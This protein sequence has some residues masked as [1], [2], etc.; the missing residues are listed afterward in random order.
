MERAE[1]FELDR[2]V[3][4]TAIRTERFKTGCVSLGLLVPLTRRTVS[5]NATL[6]YVLRRG[7]ARLPDMES[8]AAELDG[9]YGARIEPTLRKKGEIQIIGFYADFPDEAFLPERPDILGR[10]TSLMGEMLL[11]PATRGGRLRADFVATERQN[12]LDDINA[13]I[14]DKR[15]YAE[16]RVRELMF[17][18]ESYGLSKLGTSA[19]A[20]K[21]SQITLT[22]HYREVISTAPVEIFYCGPEDPGRV[23]R[24]MR[25]ALA[26]LPRAGEI[27]YPATH[28]SFERRSGAPRR[29]TERMDVTQGR[30][31]VGYRLG[32][33][34]REPNYARFLV[35]NALFGDSATSKLYL[36]LRERLSLCYYV[37]SWIDRHKGA[38]FV[39]CGIDFDKAGE[40]EAE[41]SAGLQAIAR[42]EIEDW[43]LEGA[44]REVIGALYSAADEVA[45][46]E[47]QS[48]ESAILGLGVGPEELAALASEVTAEELRDMAAGLR[49]DFVYFLTGE[50]NN[51]A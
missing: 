26:G 31:I 10:V 43:E 37:G 36:S 14:N 33:I 9:L 11:S 39:S 8:I 18:G 2:G 44:R 15:G 20:E 22:R 23:E 5:L 28:V 48:L 50:G 38:M 41:I 17:R 3:H 47:G 29:V 40:A 21:V 19:S 4:L 25:E 1:S 32:E 12:L 7:T 35:F 49:P 16:K 27:V 6:P 24:L 34:M 45:G 42:G 51:E 46:L 30:L 13:E